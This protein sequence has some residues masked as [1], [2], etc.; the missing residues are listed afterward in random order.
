MVGGVRC[1]WLQE[2]TYLNQERG[3]TNDESTRSSRRIVQFQ[4]VQGH[5]VR[6]RRHDG[7]NGCCTPLWALRA[8]IETRWSQTTHCEGL[9][10]PR[11]SLPRLPRL[12]HPRLSPLS[13][14]STNEHPNDPLSNHSLISSFLSISLLYSKP[15]QQLPTPSPKPPPTLPLSLH[16]PTPTSPRPEYLQLSLQSPHSPLQLLDDQLLVQRVMQQFQC[17]VDYTP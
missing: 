16:R 6:V 13:T 9:C 7:M 11:P 4:L 5:R 14:R 1:R 17:V 15:L 8:R 2:S 10:P 12:L 3:Q